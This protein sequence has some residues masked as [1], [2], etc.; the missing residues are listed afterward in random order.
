M[1]PGFLSGYGVYETL[2]AHDGAVE[3]LDRHYDRLKKGAEVIFGELYW[4]MEDIERWIARL[5]H[6]N[7]LK[8]ARVRIT[9]ATGE[10][11]EMILIA[12]KP[13]V[14][15]P[16]E[17]YTHGVS[18]VTYEGERPLPEIKTTNLAVQLLARRHMER[19][20]AYEVLLVDRDGKVREGSVT[21]V[22][23]VRN[24]VLVTPCERVLRGVMRGHVIVR[25]RDL[26]IRVE[27]REIK[28]SEFLKADE[29]FLTNSLKGIV[30]VVKVDGHVAG[31]GVVGRVTWKLRWAILG[32][33]G[34]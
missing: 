16:E 25:A 19:Q 10:L 3:D 4:D 8:K 6:K 12:V 29:V 33:H 32:T 28:L 2:R 11:G 9:V 26:K 24:G 31:G 5:L 34:N 27:E 20:E 7:R 17:V 15:E 18:V 30:P 13:F 14:E 23:M 22:F 21:N 1:S